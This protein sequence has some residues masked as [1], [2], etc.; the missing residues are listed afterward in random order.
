MKL[1]VVIVNYNVKHFLKQCLISVKHAID[2]INNDGEVWVVDN[3]SVDGSV[4]MLKEEFK[5]VKLIENRTNVGFAKANNQ[6]IKQ[7]KGE[8][9]LLLNPDTVVQEDTFEKTIKFMDEHPEAGALGVRMINGKGKFL[10]ESKRGFPTPRVAF[11]KM[12]GFSKLFPKSKFFN[13]YY[14]GFLDEYSINEIDVI[15]GAFFLIRKKVLDKIGMLDENFFMYGEDIDL[16]YRIKLAGYKNYYFPETTIIHYKGE[17]TKKGTL[18]YVRLFYSAMLIFT[19]KHLKSQGKFFI[20]IIKTAIYF[21]AFL[22]I[23]KNFLL[24]IILPLF[25]FTFLYFT[26]YG[27]SK[28]WEIIKY[29]TKNY[30]PIEFYTYIMPLYSI[31]I[32]AGLYYAGCYSKKSKNPDF[33][34]GAFVG[35]LLLSLFYAFLSEKVRFSRAVVL[36]GSLITIFIFL[37]LRLYI[38]NPYLL[39]KK[40]KF[41]SCILLGNTD[42]YKKSLE[43]LK[44]TNEYENI[45]FVEY[46]SDSQLKPNETDLDEIIKI[47]KP[48]EIVFCLN[49][50]SP[51]DVILI[52]TKFSAYNLNYKI[53]GDALIGSKTV[54]TNNS[55]YDI[56]I[57]SIANPINKHNK[58]LLD[59]IFSLLLIILY[60]FIVWYFKNKITLLKNLALC[61]LG[62]YTFVGYYPHPQ[63]YDLPKIKKS[64]LKITYD[65]ENALKIN[66]LYAKEYRIYNDLVIIFKNFKK[67]DNKIL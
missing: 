35:I 3:H 50:L 64:I 23:A 1:S 31:I 5:W 21:R 44:K 57:N 26:F 25:D 15:S 17:S 45:I 18:N 11:F 66:M 6:A 8:Y 16:S 30:Y 61:L 47:N 33:Y 39:K 32:V 59:I 63:N 34:K 10:P 52:M 28:F 19:S 38:I 54:I 51:K 24:Q 37:P 40:K 4:Q 36:F 9:I 49:S 22:S 42:D 27:V 13:T 14:L 7:C 41:K 53:I 55:A 43:I 20:F 56:V 29:N 65:K 2:N 46:K 58:R 60:P 12:I 48:E 67:I 62:K